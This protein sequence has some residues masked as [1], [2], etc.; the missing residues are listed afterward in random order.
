M[1]FVNPERYNWVGLT[2]CKI[3]TEYLY[4]IVSII[5]ALSH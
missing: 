1:V 2:C 5:S 3:K 4:F